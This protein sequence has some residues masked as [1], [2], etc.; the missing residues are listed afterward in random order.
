MKLF[1]RKLV[2][3]LRDIKDLKF[4]SEISTFKIDEIILNSKKDTVLAW[5]ITYKILDSYVYKTVKKLFENY[6][7][8]EY[9]DIVMRLPGY[10]I[11]NKLFLD[12][13]NIMK[14]LFEVGYKFISELDLEQIDGFSSIISQLKKEG[15]VYNN[16][17]YNEKSLIRIVYYLFYKKDME[18]DINKSKTTGIIQLH[19]YCDLDDFIL[20]YESYV[21]NLYIDY[22]LINRIRFYKNT[23]EYIST[24]C[25]DQ[26]VYIFDVD[27]DK[28]IVDGDEIIK[29]IKNPDNKCLS[30]LGLN[31]EFINRYISNKLIS[32]V[33]NSKG[34]II[35]YRYK[36]CMEDIKPITHECFDS[37]HDIFYYID[38]D[39][40]NFLY[41]INSVIVNRYS[42]LN[43]KKNGL[44]SDFPYNI[45]IS[46]NREK[47]TLLDVEDLLKLLCAFELYSKKID[48]EIAKYSM[49]ISAQYIISKYPNIKEMSTFYKIPELRYLSAGLTDE[50]IRQ[51]FGKEFSKNLFSSYCQ[52]YE[53]I[54]VNGQKYALCKEYND[55]DFV[56]IEELKEANPTLNL[57]NLTEIIELDEN[58][59][60]VPLSTQK[61]YNNI[62]EICQMD[63]NNRNL[64]ALK[65]PELLKYYVGA[66]RIVYSYYMRD[67]K[68]I[69]MYEA[70]GYICK[71]IKGEK[72]TKNNL[73][74]L[75]NK[76]LAFLQLN[77]FKF[78]DSQYVPL[79]YI[80]YDTATKIIQINGLENNIKLEKI[81]KKLKNNM[82]VI[83]DAN[84]PQLIEIRKKFFNELVLNRKYP[85][86]LLDRIDEDILAIDTQ[87]QYNKYISKLNC[88]CERHNL[89]Y[90]SENGCNI[91]NKYF[92]DLKTFE[93]QEKKYIMEDSY[94]S[95][96]SVEIGNE[97]LFIKQIKN[98][99]ANVERSIEELIYDE[100]IQKIQQLYLPLKLTYNNGVFNGYIFEYCDA[101]E[102][103][104]L[105]N[106]ELL[107]NLQRIKGCISLAKKVRKM[108]QEGYTFWK[109][110]FGKVLVVKGFN[111]EVQ[112]V[113]IEYVRKNNKEKSIRNTIL[114]TIKYIEKVIENDENILFS[115]P[116]VNYSLKS[117]NEVISVLENYSSSLKKICRKH[118]YYS[119][120]LFYCPRCINKAKLESV[121]NN[122]QYLT[123]I[124][125][126]KARSKVDEGGESVVYSLS[127]DEVIKVFKADEIDLGYKAQVIIEM[128]C[129]NQELKSIEE[130]VQKEGIYSFKYITI[131]KVNVDGYSNNINSYI[132]KKIDAMHIS[133]LKSRKFISER[134]NFTRKDILEILI[135][136]GKG[137]EYL[138]QLNIYIGDLNGRN[139]M[140]DKN[141]TVY[142]IDFDGM[143]VEGLKPEFYTDGYVDP[144]SKKN[145]T[146]EMKD[147]WYSYAI[148]AFYY[149]TY[150]HPFNGIEEGK[151]DEDIVT[152]MEKRNSV[153]GKENIK[154]PSITINWNWMPDSMIN[155][156]KD[157][158]EGECRQSMRIFFEKYYDLAYGNKYNSFKDFIGE[159][160]NYSISKDNQSPCEVVDVTDNISLTLLKT[161]DENMSIIKINDKNKY[162]FK[163]KDKKIMLNNV[164]N[165]EVSKIVEI[166][167]NEKYLYII[168][169]NRLDIYSNEK[170]IFSEHI[171][172]DNNVVVN[173]NFFYCLDINSNE[174]N[175]KHISSNDE[176]TTQKIKFKL[177]VKKFNV[178]NNSKFVII[179]QNEEGKDL[180]YCNDDLFYTFDNAD[181]D[182]KI[183]YDNNTKK[184]LIIRSDGNGIV[185]HEDGKYD[186]IEIKNT[187]KTNI[188]NFLWD[189]NTIYIPQQNKLIVYNTLSKKS[190][191]IELLNLI[192]ENS[193]IKIYEKGFY[194]INSNKI[195]KCIFN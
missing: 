153:I 169:K 82:L 84:E 50:I 86:L 122:I 81:S 26:E 98:K 146:V 91:C 137:I 147:D 28:E 77:L 133:F 67:D 115:L 126:N 18:K 58:T 59:T 1:G 60:F 30:F 119:D 51:I 97:K 131:D 48:I 195:Y 163:E 41:D 187:T 129:K 194:I 190:K 54:T 42:I 180:V 8:E 43:M 165:E 13:I 96:Y 178:V 176:I 72:L 151:E 155:T 75:D 104:D 57:D 10:D 139:I 148:Q 79:E 52:Y 184:W 124:P 166:I 14:K 87:E 49:K 174:I 179:T 154:V 39:F 145:N 177:P 25:C 143:G 120:K 35:G 70:V 192:D 123:Q 53:E 181:T 141:K 44:L 80:Y 3:I 101:N 88:Y 92:V 160:E 186:K 90:N 11:R 125:K 167:E 27:E 156:F 16:S 33:Y 189:Y 66:K 136:I 117:L 34:R 61:Q 2:P 55:S 4:K 68:D 159:K 36:K 135:N 22:S 144:I 134:L 188:Y 89:Y 20:M 38:T 85:K 107:S 132:M 113:N 65:Y 63:N 121:S 24:D 7:C 168:F 73:R 182:Y 130:K 78:F 21:N 172:S 157:I 94:A 185:I 6:Y 106:Y 164:D 116:S 74:K 191:E 45:R 5:K 56:F 171:S 105:E 175:E 128:M 118:G 161:I 99:E 150:T 9:E 158:F 37:I 142:F 170:L 111:N 31:F 112:I 140:F 47:I 114:Y 71:K 93:T 110:P 193:K 127:N 69:N 95:Y 40:R 32:I 152:R 173:G 102:F 17:I 103:C 149:L 100:Q 162:Y 109:N 15:D 29:V 62:K 138:H 46:N 108:I 183:L 23:D 12:F 83:F 64:I 76:D 19:K